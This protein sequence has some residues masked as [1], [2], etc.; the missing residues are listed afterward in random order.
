[1][2]KKQSSTDLKLKAVKYYRKVNN[3][4]KVCKIFECSE[5][6]LKRWV[7]TS[8]NRSLYFFIIFLYFFVFLWGFA[9]F[10]LF[11]FDKKL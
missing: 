3:Y 7:V 2:I 11:Y 1:M 9:V 6:S 8:C 5:R 10:L 4:A